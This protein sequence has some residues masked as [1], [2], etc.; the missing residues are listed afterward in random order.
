[1]PGARCTARSVAGTLPKLMS[2]TVSASTG[3]R[4]ALAQNGDP[5]RHGVVGVE[6]ELDRAEQ[7]AVVLGRDAHG[8]GR[9]AGDVAGDRA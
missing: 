8:V 9:L 4:V 3:R 7:A 1:M 2:V 5:E 6:G